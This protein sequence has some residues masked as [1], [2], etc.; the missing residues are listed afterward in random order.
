MSAPLLTPCVNI[1]VVHREAGI[2]VGCY[3]T[4]DEIAAWG[5]MTNAERAEIMDGLAA[6]AVLLRKRR[7]G[8]AGRIARGRPD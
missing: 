2:C 1:C 3:R 4:P 6:R 5:G 7:G 8:R